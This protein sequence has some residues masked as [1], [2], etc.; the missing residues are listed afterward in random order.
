MTVVNDY[1]V[2]KNNYYKYASV[3]TILKYGKRKNENYDLS[4][5]V[6]T[7]KKPDKLK[8]ALESVIKQDRVGLKVEIIIVD[9]DYFN[10]AGSE[11]ERILMQYSEEQVAY[12]QNEKNIG[13]YGNWNRCIELANAEWVAMLHDDD[14]LSSDYFKNIKKIIKK[15]NKDGKLVFVRGLSVVIHSGEKEE[16]KGLPQFI[17]RTC[18]SKI[19]KFNSIDYDIIG[20]DKIGIL[21]APSCGT[22]MKR[23]PYLK[24]GG[25]DETHSPSADVYFPER[26]VTQHGYKVALT[27][28]FLGYARF[29]DNTSLKEDAILGWAKEYIVYQEYYRSRSKLAGWL[30]KHFKNEMGVNQRRYYEEC[31]T[32]SN[33]IADKGN[34]S[35]K[36]NQIMDYHHNIFKDKVYNKLWWFTYFRLKQLIA[37]ITT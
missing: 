11:T 13:M 27:M 23:E 34:T 3:K 4:F 28:G 9:N 22:I 25:F 29:D 35:F 6:P 1:A 12:Y 30:F 24:Y 37:L 17:H 33:F 2:D 19:I 14:Y 26:L 7:Y 20:P 8:D 16:R 5:V 18:K 10:L 36:I 32:K 15:A 21:G 31:L